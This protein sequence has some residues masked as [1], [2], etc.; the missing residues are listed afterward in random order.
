MLTD[1]IITIG[2]ELDLKTSEKVCSIDEKT[3]FIFLLS[4]FFYLLQKAA[5]NRQI[6]E[7]NYTDL[8]IV[9]THPQTSARLRFM[10]Q[11]VMDLRKANWVARRAEAKPTTI[12]EIH[13]QKRDKALH[14]ESNRD[15]N[16]PNLAR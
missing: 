10:I 3:R 11:D 14:L 12:D 7:K 6:L 8:F 5:A 1:L 13:E 15:G 4:V 2:K 9:T 16:H